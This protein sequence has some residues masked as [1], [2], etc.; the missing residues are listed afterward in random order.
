MNNP[1]KTKAPTGR[2]F[3]GGEVLAWPSGRAI[4]DHRARLFL[5]RKPPPLRRCWIVQPLRLCS[6]G[7]CS[8]PSIFT[9]CRAALPKMRICRHWRRLIQTVKRLN[10][11]LKSSDAEEPQFFIKVITTIEQSSEPLPS[12]VNPELPPNTPVTSSKQSPA[13]AEKPTPGTKDEPPPYSQRPPNPHDDGSAHPFSGIAVIPGPTIDTAYFEE[14]EDAPPP[15]YSPHPLKSQHDDGSSL[16]SPVGPTVAAGP[17]DNGADSEGTA[18]YPTTIRGDSLVV[19]PTTQWS[20]APKV[21]RYLHKAAHSNR[22]L[23]RL[24]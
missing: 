2:A 1:P 7:F 12:N 14:T 5:K 17:T 10:C 19:P 23:P 4:A 21:V 22:A 3:I 13:I 8:L 20:N 6:R 11:G 16:S 18:A 15:A 24:D 9:P